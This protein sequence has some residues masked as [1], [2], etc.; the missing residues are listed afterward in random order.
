[1][2]LDDTDRSTP[3]DPRPEDDRSLG[4]R[5][6]QHALWYA[7]AVLIVLIAVAFMQLLR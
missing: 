3:S 5:R 4:D 2:N 7:T 6:R 1:M